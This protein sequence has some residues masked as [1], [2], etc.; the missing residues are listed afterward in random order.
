L[1]GVTATANS[2]FTANLTSAN[3]TSGVTYDAVTGK[4]SVPIGVTTF[5]VKVTTLV[6]NVLGE[7]PNET[8]KLSIGG[9]DGIGSIVDTTNNPPVLDLD[10]NNSS[11]ATGANFLTSFTENGAAVSIA[12]IDVG[13]TDV[14]SP[15]LTKATITLTNAQVGD[16]LAFGT[17]PLGI[18]ANLSGNVITLTGSS[19]LINYQTAI[20]AITFAST[21]E[22]PSTIPRVLTVVVS[23]GISDSNVAQTTINVIAVNDPPIDANET[24]TVLED[25][26]LSVTDGAAGDLLNNATDAEGNTLSIASYNIAGV[27]GTQTVGAPVV[28]A[29]VGT[30]TINANG[31]YSFAPVLNYTGAIPVITYT[32]T[33][34][35]GGTDTSTLTLTMTPVNDPPVDDNETNT[36]TEDTTLTVANGAAGD[37]LN[38]A[39]DVDGN[40]LSIASYTIAGILGT[41]AVGTPVLIAGVGTLTINANGSYSFAPV[42]NYT[43]AIPIITYTVTD[44]N[45]GTD[46]STLTLSM[47]AVNDPPVDANETNTVTEDTTLSVGDG[48]AGDLLNNATDPDGNTLSIASYTIAGVVGTQAIGTPVVIAGVGT[49]TINANGSYSFA[50]VL[51]YTGAIPVITYTVTDGNGGLDTSTLTLSMTTVNDPPVNTVPVAQSTN[52]DVSKVFSVATGNAIT[53]ADIDSASV[54]T[55]LTVTN[56]LLTAIAAAGVVITGNGTASVTLVGSPTAINAA[57]NG[58]SFAGTADYNG[59]ANL[60]VSTNDGTSTTS[61]SVAI[62]ITPVGD[63]VNDTGTTNEET[64]INLNVLGNDTFEN[65]GRVITAINGTPVTVGTPFAVTNGTATLL[66]NGTINFLPSTNFTGSTNFTYTVTS[67]GVTE[68]ATATVTV[69]PVNDAPIA[70]NSNGSVS[71]EGLVNGTP[72]PSG[73]PDTTNATSFTGTMVVT[74]PDSSTFTWNLTS[75][76]SGITS[77]N[78]PVTWVLSGKTYTG[79]AGAVTVATMSINDSGSYTF[80]LLKPIDHATPNQEDGKT[81]SFGTSVSDGSATS[82][83]TISINVEDDAPNTITP[84]VANLNTIDT[85]LIITLDVSGSM[86]ATDGVGGTSRLVSAVNSIKALLDKYDEFGNVAVRLVTFSTNADPQGTTWT[87]VAAAKTLLDTIVAN[88][89]NGGTNYDAA[90]AD[91]MTAFASTGKLTNAQN[92]GYFFSDGAPTYGS[93]GTSVLDDGTT[94]GNGSS[95]TS[96]P[97]VGIQA[98]EETIWRNFLTSNYMKTYAIGI[99]TGITDVTQLNPIAFDGSTGNNLNGAIVSSLAGLDAFLA[100]TISN[101]VGGSLVTGGIAANLGAD[102]GFVKSLLIN[103]VT[104]TYNPAGAGSITVSGGAGSYV[105]DTSTNAITVTTSTGGKFVVDMDDGTYKYFAPGSVAGTLS[106]VMG[107]TMS[108]RDGDTQSSSITVNVTQVNGVTSANFSGDAGAN[109][110]M[111]GAGND[112]IN[113]LG[114][115]DKLFGGAGNDS[116]NGG[117]G[118]DVLVGGL[119]TDT[120]TG[121]TG[122]D[123]FRLQRNDATTTITDFIPGTDKIAFFEGTAA[124]AVNFGVTGTVAGAALTAGDGNFTQRTTIATLNATDD[125]QLVVITT[126]QTAAQIAAATGVDSQNLYVVVFNSTSNRAE[127]WFD[128]NWTDAGTRTLVAVLNGV[129]AAQVAALTASDF[130]VYGDLLAAP[131]MLLASAESMLAA[132]VSHVEPTLDLASARSIH[133]PQVD[134]LGASLLIPSVEKEGA[135]HIDAQQNRD[136]LS[137]VKGHVHGNEE[138][139]VSAMNSMYLDTFAWSLA[140]GVVHPSVE[141]K[142]HDNEVT[143]TEKQ[144]QIDLRELLIEKAEVLPSESQEPSHDKVN[145][146]AMDVYMNLEMDKALIQ[147]MILKGKLNTD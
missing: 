68:T 142:T 107:F 62:T 76:P 61:N 137:D 65:A 28:V 66:A 56:G 121:G 33:D 42:L 144:E 87:T 88:G 51:N 48:A 139:D 97:D 73:S 13:I 131:P 115:S 15:N 127:I 128:T 3:F 9:K 63:I 11:T 141:N 57:L 91:T 41:Q 83:A 10:A 24:N 86:A 22:N 123:Q 93:G 102:G 95:P 40:T 136:E 145:N 25:T 46:T 45:G 75:A 110:I 119:G 101:P 117:D 92:I 104:Y 72:D 52:E 129:T 49:L 90:L 85:N 7:S 81:L 122:V 55:T 79:T 27:V 58:L 69:N 32:V 124:D 39:T 98:A 111:G 89:P 44:G 105:F 78:V 30:I 109:T 14:D 106:E 84:I 71:E 134:K 16:V 108:D 53:V 146:E 135:S 112:Q 125:N 59:N 4:I 21:S 19:S 47:T 6:D 36:V 114:G 130:V 8:L 23:D 1:V 94:L 37:L 5:S 138:Q 34:G 103:G 140:D 2:D 67:G 12:D 126:A 74:D 82:T 50:P 26:T 31:S 18:T 77:D 80:T 100:G 17:M 38:N 29:G 120:M 118:D 133:S 99:G 64:L 54:T 43:G 132:S 60:T 70:S 147:D 35:N 143:T 113:G 116:L 96:D 20:K